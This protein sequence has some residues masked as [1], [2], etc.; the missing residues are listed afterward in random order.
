VR[1]CWKTP[2]SGRSTDRMQTNLKPIY[3]ILSI[4]GPEILKFVGVAGMSETVTLRWCRINDDA[5]LVSITWPMRY[6]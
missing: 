1:S 2:A 5:N 4:V 3:A 6:S